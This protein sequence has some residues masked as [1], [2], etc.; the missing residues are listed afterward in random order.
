M[1]SVTPPP[2]RAR[3]LDSIS[4]VDRAAW[5]RL[6]GAAC[7][8]YDY[9]LACE[10][11]PA[12]GFHYRALGV[13]AGQRLIAGCPVFSVTLPLQTLVDGPLRTLVSV[14]G[15]VLP[16]LAQVRLLGLG[17]PH[18]DELPLVIDQTLSDRQRH[19][20]LKA[21]DQ[22]LSEQAVATDADAVLWK[23]LS[24]Q[25]QS[26][27]AP[28]LH[29]RRYTPIAGLP[30]ATLNI[31]EN[32]EAYI[33]SLSA[34]MRSNI[35]RKLKRAKAI[36]VEI[37]Q[38]TAGL[39]ERITALRDQTRARAPTDYD[40]FEELSPDYVSSVLAQMPEQSRLLLYWLEN[41]LIGFAL[42][43]IESGQI[44]EKYTG[45]QYPEALEHGVFFLNWVSIV[46]LCQSQRIPVFRAG[47]TTYLT[48]TRL[49][50]ELHPSWH[51]VRHRQPIV[52]WVLGRIS[53]QFD[54]DKAD[55]DLRRL[56][57]FDESKP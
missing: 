1:S 24:D 44:K 31:P 48:K 10:R 5:D 15:R 7:E 56:G 19:Q 53:R 54:L 6:Y 52:N 47:E 51:F 35:R 45:L 50:C 9:F 43:L 20:V 16:G 14:A 8:G 4:D 34:N 36:R 30:V 29:A 33:Q 18:V 11:A 57:A 17:S 25:Q 38:D 12:P 46:R 42:V 3:L 27:F 23:N 49:G 21:I 39:D 13:F 28:D 26:A 40:V 41:R 22:A 37:R 2:Y 32:D 55:P